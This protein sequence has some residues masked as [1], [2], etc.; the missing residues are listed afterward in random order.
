MIH[1]HHALIICTLALTGCGAPLHS[2]HAPMHDNFA[3]CFRADNSTYYEVEAGTPCHSGDHF[4]YPCH[5]PNG[6]VAGVGKGVNGPNAEC[7]AHGGSLF[8]GSFKK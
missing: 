3:D 5:L 4:A 1:R 2:V 6:V 8:A 7:R